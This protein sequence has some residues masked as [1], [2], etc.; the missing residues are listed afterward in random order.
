MGAYLDH[1]KAGYLSP[2]VQARNLKLFGCVTSEDACREEHERFMIA[3]RKLLWPH[4]SANSSSS[5]SSDGSGS[6]SA[7]RADN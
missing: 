4:L 6:G 1:T 2:E 7:Q 3:K 5:D